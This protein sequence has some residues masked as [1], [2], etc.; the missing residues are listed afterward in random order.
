MLIYI[1]KFAEN[2]Y[3]LVRYLPEH[4]VDDT[5]TYCFDCGK[6]QVTSMQCCYNFLEKV[7]ARKDYLETRQNF[8]SG[9]SGWFFNP[10]EEEQHRKEERERYYL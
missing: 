4:K 8:T 10:L 2:T 5:N 1:I 9:H 3:Y 7:E 6:R